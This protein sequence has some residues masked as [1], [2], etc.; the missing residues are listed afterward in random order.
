M[1]LFITRVMASRMEKGQKLTRKQIVCLASAISA[2][3]MAAIAEGYMDIDDV[4]IKNLQYENKDNAEAFNREVIKLW[5]NQNPDDQIQVNI[6]SLS[7][8]SNHR[9]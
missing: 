8:A 9:K 4:T 7:I 6:I 1:L 3:N 5:K 2:N